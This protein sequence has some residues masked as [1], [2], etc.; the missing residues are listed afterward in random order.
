MGFDAA[1]IDRFARKHMP[2]PNSGCWLWTAAVNAKGYGVMKAPTGKGTA[3][4]HRLSYEMHLGPI[5]PGLAVCHRCDNPA[6]VNPDHLF[7]GTMKE[8]SE[9]MVAKK[10]SRFG[11]RHG[12]ARLTEEQVAEIR[13]LAADG[14]RTYDDIAVEFGISDAHC[15]GICSGR[16]WKHTYTGPTR[17]RASSNAVGFI[18]VTRERHRFRATIARGA[19]PSRVRRSL[20]TYGTAEEAARAYD[21]AAREWFG[22]DARLNFPGGAA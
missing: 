19:A 3:Y 7:L 6:C 1:F 9:D 16:F 18:G 17:Q 14:N 10:R 5:E 15:W 13:R 21:R 12:L 11:E 8:N 2:E 22:E 4:A 20:G